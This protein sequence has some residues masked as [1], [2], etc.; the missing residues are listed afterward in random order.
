MVVVTDA[1]ID[2]PLC[3]SCN[4]CTQLNSRIFAYNGNKQAEVKDAGA[5]PFSDIVRAAELCP[6]HIIHPGKPKNP[7]EPGL[8]EWVK[9]AE[10]YN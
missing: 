8:D 6:V 5:G 10:R 1:Y 9:R 4:E 7:S 3:T 2:T